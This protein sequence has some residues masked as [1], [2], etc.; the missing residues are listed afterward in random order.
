MLLLPPIATEAQTLD[1][2][3]MEQMFGEPVTTSVTGKPQRAQDAPANIEIVTQD[4]IRRSGATTIPDVLRF[5]TGIDVRETGIGSEEVGIRGYNQASNPRLMVLVDGRQVYMV[6]YGRIVWSAIPVQLDEIRQIEVIK[7]PNSALYGFNAVGGVINI[8][9]YDPRKDPL[10]VATARIGTQDYGGG[11]VVATGRAGDGAGLRLSLGGFKAHDFPPGPLDR[12][13]VEARRPPFTGVL[14]ADGRWQ[15][16]P[17][18]EV[19]ADVSAGNTSLS[20]VGPAGETQT[21]WL[22]TNAVNFG[23]TAD[24]AAGLF[25]LSAGRNEARST[26]DNVTSFGAAVYSEYETTWLIQASDLL[27]LGTD[28]TLR[29]MLE[30]RQNADSSGELLGGHITNSIYSAGVMWDWQVTPSLSLTNAVRLDYLQLSDNGALLPFTGYKT[31]D[32]NNAMTIEPSLN[33]GAVWRA[34]D[35]DTLRLTLARAVQLPTLLEYALQVGPGLTGPYALVGR[36][37]LHPAIV[38]NLELDYDRALPALGSTLRTALFAQRTDDIMSSPFGVRPVFTSAGLPIFFSQNVGYSTDA[39]V[40]IDVK[41]HNAEG[42]RWNASYALAA[43]TDHTSLNRGG[44]ITSP[45]AYTISAPRSVVIGG[46]GWTHDRLEADLQARWQ[47]SF[48]DYRGTPTP[49]YLLPV[50]IDNYITMNA[51]IGYRLT[52]N[53]TIALTARQFN[54]SSLVETAGPP[55][56]RQIIASL[57]LRL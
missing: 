48:L 54:Q 28:H 49:P 18:V 4:D 17:N 15:V 8:I 57:T 31:S 6:D 34:T 51:R 21:E 13:D 47:S 19:F 22:V 3:A 56:Q 24:T 37:D 45:V 41:G 55:V 14:N 38:W 27:K 52:D 5:V 39:G 30:F 25:S 11:S 40:E 35:Q 43:T 12:T 42:F 50:S 7:G 16:N 20:E 29:F 26:F 36:P 44:F 33:S 32:Y 53:L 10:N 23:F 46:V 9:T 2:G 1:Y